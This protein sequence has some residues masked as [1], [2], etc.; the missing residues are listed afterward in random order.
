MTP[1]ATKGASLEEY[2]SADALAVVYGKFFDIKYETFH[3]P[4]LNNNQN[5]LAAFSLQEGGANE[6][7]LRQSA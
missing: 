5:L 4:P 2:R 1:H 6:K 7:R 3:V